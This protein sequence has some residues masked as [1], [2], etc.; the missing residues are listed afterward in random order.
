MFDEIDDN[1]TKGELLYDFQ[2]V[3]HNVFQLMSHRFRAAQQEQQKEQYH[4]EMDE[5]TALLTIDWAQTILPR[6]FRE[7]ESSYFGKKRHESS[8]WFIRFQATTEE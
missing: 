4:N 3:W 2:L 8:R 7:G 1:E 6:Q 5:A